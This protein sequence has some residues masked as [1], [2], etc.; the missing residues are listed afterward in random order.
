MSWVARTITMTRMR[1]KTSKAMNITK[2][3][4]LLGAVML[5]A[6]SDSGT[7]P[8]TGRAYSAIT[9]GY[10]H[11]CALD[12]NGAAWCW[13]N[14]DFGT[15]GDGTRTHRSVPTRVAGSNAFTELDAG[16]AHNCVIAAGG[17]ARCWGHNDEGQLGDGTFTD[18]TG[19]ADVSGAITFAHVS[20]GHA[21]SC[22]ATAGGAAFCWG[23][24]TRGQLGNDEEGATRSNTPVRVIF[25]GSFDRVYAG[26]YQSCAL[27]PQGEAYCWGGGE[28]GQNG[29]STR[30]TSHLPVRV[31]TSRRFQSLAAGDRFICG[32]SSGEV[33]CWGANRNGE[34]GRAADSGSAFPVRVGSITNAMAV[35]ASMGTS[36][37]G[38]SAEPY[39]CAVL[40]DNRVVCWGGI[41]PPLRGAGPQP[42]ELPGAVRG[43]QA[44]T[45]AIHLC[46]LTGEREVWCG[47]ANGV[48]Q[49]GDGTNTNRASLVRVTD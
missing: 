42:E 11:T 5:V 26:Y 29:D 33:W 3:W 45:G 25:N 47:G 16:A 14:N 49:L 22:G 36:T 13:G 41:V 2:W 18:R 1:G 10:F 12:L 8:R 38:S 15:L 6:C 28:S 32:V 4:L 9:T 48:G 31:A 19:L 30:N 24:D 43:A 23:D 21:H 46:V 7:E 40:S 27:T 37:I 39:A 20:A 34:L 44:A 17:I 35:Y